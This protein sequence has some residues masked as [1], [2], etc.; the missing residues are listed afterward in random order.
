MNNQTLYHYYFYISLYNNNENLYLSKY[1]NSPRRIQSK[2]SDNML[3]LQRK[4]KINKNT[5]SLTS[6]HTHA[7]T[8]T[9]AHTLARGMHTRKQG[10]IQ[11]ACINTGKSTGNG[12]EGGRLGYNFFLYTFKKN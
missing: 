10:H 11:R 9:H 12:G 5:H 2:N 8:H 6:Q 7:R 4:I 1:F 3:L